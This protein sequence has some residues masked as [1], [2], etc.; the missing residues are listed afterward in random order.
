MAN[1]AANVVAGHP[2]VTGGIL[3]APLGTALPTDAV[4]AL[5][6][7]FA[8][9]GYI[10]NDGVEK[11]LAR[12]TDQLAAWGS[13][14]VKVNQTKFGV[15]LQFTLIESLNSDVLKAAFG[16]TNVT[17][18]AANGSH[19]TQQA[20]KINALQLDRK[21]WALE[22]KDGVVKQRIVVPDGQVIEVGQV[23]YTDSDIVGFQLTVQAFPNSSADSAYFYTDDG[24]TV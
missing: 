9:L 14:I 17:T 11:T 10:A 16:T 4:T 12:D 7:S 3:W 18:T 15:T 21:S 8:S 22:I 23:K 5:N 19:G 13:D 1:T 6:G 20:A 2:L 24:V